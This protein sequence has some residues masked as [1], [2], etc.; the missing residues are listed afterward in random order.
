MPTTRRS[1]VA[2]SVLAWLAGRVRGET[3]SAA[4][5]QPSPPKQVPD[6]FPTTDLALQQ[7]MVGVSHGKVARVRELLGAHPALAKASWDWGY[8]DAETA[9]GAASHVG[10]REIAELL[11]AGGA[12]PTLFS[13][14][15]LGQLEAVKALITAAPGIQRTKG[16]HGI[17]L[18]AHARAGGEPAAAVVAYLETLG[19]ADPRY[20]D[21][22]VP[23]ADRQA[24]VGR[25]A[26]G[27][28]PTEL[29]IVE[30]GPR[31]ISIQRQGG[32]A[33]GLLH[34]GERAFHPVGAEAVR[35]RFAT[36]APAPSL[37][38]EDGPQSLTAI[39]SAG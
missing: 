31:G 35:V 34:Q 10:N 3:P 9:L 6:T 28:G 17:N 1:L 5:P 25:Y 19:D 38:V 18:L 33:R 20:T 2:F 14:A 27:G 26:F 30:S 16:P 24:I 21:L 4:T 22:A 11:L 7:E 15:M 32:V 39:R 37:T 23:E 13:A 29:M 8:G 36:G 12:P